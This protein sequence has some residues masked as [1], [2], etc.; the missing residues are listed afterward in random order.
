MATPIENFN[1]VEGVNIDE[2]QFTQAET[3]SAQSLIRQYVSD[4]YVDLDLTE[5]S[6]L[7]DLVIRPLTQVFL[8]IKKL[9]EDFSKTNTLYEAVN[10][11]ETASN[12]I[13]DALLSNFSIYRRNGNL[14]TGKIKVNIQGAP[15][16][17][18]FPQ[19]MTFT[20]VDGLVFNPQSE[21]VAAET[22]TS[23]TQLKLYTDETGT[24]SYALVPVAA[25]SDGSA[26]NVEQ[27][28]PF[29]VDPIS[30]NLVTATAFSRFTGGDDSETNEQVINRLI[31]ALSTRNLASPVAI[32]QTLRDNF[33]SIQ[34]ISIHAINSPLMTR[35]SHNIFGIKAGCMCDVYVK[36]SSSLDEYYVGATAS[37][38]TTASEYADLQGY[39]GKYVVRV[40]NDEKLGPCIPG[41]YEVSRVTSQESGVFGTYPI[42]LNQRGY[43]NLSINSQQEN[44]LF[45]VK[46]ATYSSYANALIVFDPMLGYG[47]PVPSLAV[48]VYALAL[49]DIQRIQSYVN[50]GGTQT[51][52]VD[53]LVKAVVPCFIETSEIKVSVKTGTVKA[54]QL[55]DLL[56]R[57]I[58]SVDPKN[59]TIRIDGLILA[60]KD[61]E[62]V[63]SVNTPILI[64]GTVLAPDRN[65]TNVSFSTESILE[66][67]TRLDLGFSRTNIGFFT[68]GENV[69]LTIIE[70]KN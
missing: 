25:D 4:K 10:L 50:E 35:N 29:T 41:L 16:S 38:I 9:I 51:A 12:N 64:T 28:T 5:L 1:L 52:L 33:P 68:R 7:N 27:Y 43:G 49:P 22:P 6:S 15:S 70:A 57:Y 53:T 30:F 39:L 26:Y 60:L 45:D 61:N 48:N 3:L 19:E 34:Q 46:E 17:V 54:E 14:S 21:F 58:S 31:P 23:A 56:I 20:T 36:T 42:L 13:V 66:V 18:S 11:P 63:I 55:K 59:D 37:L 44:Y 32:E 69:P 65:M 67:P 62:N 2:S 8:V 40:T 24:Q 47:T